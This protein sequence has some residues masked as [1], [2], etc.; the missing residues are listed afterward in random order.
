MSDYQLLSLKCDKQDQ[1]GSISSE[2]TL[3]EKQCARFTCVIQHHQLFH[4]EK[5]ILEFDL[6]LLF[7]PNVPPK[8][9]LKLTHLPITIAESER[10]RINSWND[11][12]SRTAIHLLFQEKRILCGSVEARFNSEWKKDAK[13][14][15]RRQIIPSTSQII[16]AL[17]NRKSFGVVWE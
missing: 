13:K 4:K 6:P 3:D 11:L 7:R 17:E 12:L 14:L 5:N 16:A 2:L 10:Q 8:G 15:S 1:A 9:S